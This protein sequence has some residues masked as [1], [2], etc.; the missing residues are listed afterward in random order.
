[1]KKLAILSP[2]VLMATTTLAQDSTCILQP[3][4]SQLGYTSAEADCGN[5]KVLRCPFDV[6]QVACI[7]GSGTSGGSGGGDDTG[8]DNN[9]SPSCN[10][11]DIYY[12]DNTC[13]SN[14]NIQKD[15][16][17][18]VFDTTHR[19]IVSLSNII[20]KKWSTSSYIS[21]DV[22]ITG[23]GINDTAL[24]RD[25]NGKTYTNQLIASSSTY[26][27]AEYCGSLTLGN[28]SWFLP[29]GGQMYL[30]GQQY[31]KVNSATTKINFGT[32][33][34]LAYYEYSDGIHFNYYYW[35]SNMWTQTSKAI[36]YNFDR[37]IGGYWYY[38]N[39][40]TAGE[41]VEQDGSTYV[42]TIFTRC[43]AEY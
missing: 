36:V 30:L 32:V 12:A 6:S 11:G 28:K 21:D 18:I 31:N 9:T 41:E 24:V 17:G 2:L 5:Q 19:F 7:G 22:N 37:D 26:P 10:I 33:E 1:M 25:F 35:T 4:C 39:I 14:F 34:P 13:S 16:I 23:V 40:N 20:S 15:A 42:T 29:S 27:A 8:D 3:S 43:I 38:R